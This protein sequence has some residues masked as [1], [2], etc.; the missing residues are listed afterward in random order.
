MRQASDKLSPAEA[1]RFTDRKKGFKPETW[2]E[3]IS[4]RVNKQKPKT[5]PKENPSGA[6]TPP[7][8]T[9]KPK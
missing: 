2:G 4:G 1:R 7:R 3:A 8:V 9:G 6:I 5:F